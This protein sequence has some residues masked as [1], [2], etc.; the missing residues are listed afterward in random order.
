MK[1]KIIY[2]SIFIVLGIL[3]TIFIYYKATFPKKVIEKNYAQW[4]LL[5]YQNT[6]DSGEYLGFLYEQNYDINNLPANY[7][8]YLLINYYIAYES[9]FFTDSNEIDDSLYQKEVSK[10]KLNQ[11]LKEM[12]GP[13]YPFIEIQNTT[14]SCGKSIS[15]KNNDTYVIK[16][17]HPEICGAFDDTK[18]QYI[19]HIDNYTK[20]G[21][22]IFINIKVAYMSLSAD[23][24]VVLYNNKNKL[25]VLDYNFS[26]DCIANTD[27]NCYNTFSNYQVVLQKA[28][29]NNYYF[30]SITKV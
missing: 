23:E 15:K 18:E 30:Y 2:F 21:N 13:D 10:E 8:Q 3:L 17:K 20:K 25:Q 6:I 22:Q 26:Y 29:D 5:R 9:D 7:V 19:S 12:F 16:S 11:K 28:S 14:Y 27:K 4:D 1:K 24:R